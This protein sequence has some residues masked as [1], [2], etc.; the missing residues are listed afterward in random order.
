ME[1]EYRGGQ[2][3]MCPGKTFFFTF[4]EV[5]RFERVSRFNVSPHSVESTVV[6]VAIIHAG[7][8]FINSSSDSR[9]TRPF[10]KRDELNLTISRREIAAG[11]RKESST[12]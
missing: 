7:D 10:F 4:D 11:W 12:R 2:P 1:V 6:F 5:L 3:Q 9:S 8:L